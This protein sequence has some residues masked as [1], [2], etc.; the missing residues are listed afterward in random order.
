MRLGDDQAAFLP[1]QATPFEACRTVSTTVSSLSL[2]RS[3]G[4]DYSVP[5]RYAHHPVVVKR[6]RSPADETLETSDLEK[7]KKTLDA[8]QLPAYSTR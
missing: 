5:V 2:V 1:L 3:D 8:R 6:L 4:N 7:P